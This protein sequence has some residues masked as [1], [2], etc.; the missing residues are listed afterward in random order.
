MAPRF[1][2]AVAEERKT[3]EAILSHA[4]GF[5]AADAAAWLDRSGHENV[6]AYSGDDGVA[7]GLVMIPM[8]QFFGGRSVPMMGVAGVGIAPEHRG[9]GDAT[10]MMRAALGAMRAR[11]AAISTL[12]PATVPLYRRAGY[13][14]AGGRFELRIA[15]RE[16]VAATNVDASL[17]LRRVTELD[18]ALASAQRAFAARHPGSLDRGPHL[19]ARIFAPRKLEPRAIV[20][21]DARGVAGHLVVAHRQVDG[22][23]TEVVVVDASARDGAV[24]RRILAMLGD[25]RSLAGRVVMWPNVPSVFSM[26]LPERHYELMMP[27][28]W[29]VRVLDVEAALSARGY[30]R[31][32][33]GRFELAIED[34][35]LSAN[36]GAFV[37]E[38]AEGRAR[39]QRGGSGAVRMHVR[40]L[41]PLFTGFLSAS[42]LVRLGAIV[43]SE[44][45]AARLDAVFA[46][47]LPTM[48]EMF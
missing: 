41:A 20:L 9:R 3:L 43:A 21:E 5:P 4:F 34:D 11:G 46:G 31:A 17:S 48:T 33:S 8:G 10:A 32:T 47:P 28:S 29:M 23:D 14:R 13:E 12:Y 26:L 38:V 45:D 1:D 19:W 37:I 24:A 27:E 22:H 7:G 36:D 30:P 2:V 18:D 40:A 42:E 16:L 15:P 44:E 6:Y 25:Y 39:M 35:V